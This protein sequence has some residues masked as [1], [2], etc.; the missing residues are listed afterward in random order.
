MYLIKNRAFDIKMTTFSDSQMWHFAGERGVYSC[1]ASVFKSCFDLFWYQDGIFCY[2]LKSEK[3]IKQIK[4]GGV[5]LFGS[6]SFQDPM[7]NFLMREEVGDKVT[8]M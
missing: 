7:Q 3:D 6:V 2:R 5:G 8:F 1:N 4:P